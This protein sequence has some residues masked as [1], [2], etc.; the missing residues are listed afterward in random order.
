M[1]YYTYYRANNSYSRSLRAELAEEEG[2]EPLSRAH[3]KLA[4]ELNEYSPNRITQQSVKDALASE[5][6]RLFN[7]EYHHVGRFA[8]EVNYYPAT[9]ASFLT[10]IKDV[11]M[12]IARTEMRT[13]LPAIRAYKRAQRQLRRGA[14][15]HAMAAH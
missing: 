1:K 15:N 6:I 13:W 8:S 5:H 7:A 14:S 3:V 12:R 2:R 11:R 10:A 4:R 9:I